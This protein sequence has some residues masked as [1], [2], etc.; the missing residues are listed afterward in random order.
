[1]TT[2]Y[3]PML[4]YI[5]SYWSQLTRENK[6]DTGTL[7][8]L[9]FPYVVPG[10]GA[11]FQEMY[12]WDSYFTALGLVGSKHHHL[13]VDMT[14]NMAH[15]LERFGMIP[16]A[17]R[18]YFL[19]RSQPPFFLHMV[20]LALGVKR[21]RGDADLDIWL[22][23]ML[24]LAEAEH[25]TV[26]HGTA[27]PHHRLVHA[28]L[29]RYFDINFLDMLASC[30]SGWD[31]STR[32]GD[33]WLSFLP[34]DLNSILYA[35]EIKMADFAAQLDDEER[36]LQWRERAGVRAETMRNIFWSDEL[37]IF[38]DYDYTAGKHDPTPTLAG[39]YPLWAGL[40]T[41]LQAHR[42]ITRWLPQFEQAGGLVTSLDALAGRQ[43]AWPNGWAP[44]QQIVNE[45]LA[46][47]GY[48]DDAQ[49]LREKWCNMCAELHARTG[50]LWEKYNVVDP[51]SE[52]EAGLYGHVTGFGWTNGVIVDFVRK[53][54]E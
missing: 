16:N 24:A 18:Y 42:M 22:K 41:E 52:G 37:E 43:W 10:V 44:L 28:G 31:H 54:D 36:A 49:R 13:V 8:G 3:S 29:S 2:D 15:L 51:A 6:S 25:E 26:W 20:E 40:A 45:G 11:M 7:I 47:Y 33:R 34:V 35:R 5:D 48:V 30:E 38:L 50:V 23:R 32:C 9:P 1:M 39:F 12:Y 46:R 27:Q 53:L 4:A 19:S 14:E 21:L 17:S